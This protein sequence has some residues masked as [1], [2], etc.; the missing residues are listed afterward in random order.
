MAHLDDA[1]LQSLGRSTAA[2]GL[3]TERVY[4]PTLPDWTPK[5]VDN[6]AARQQ[7]ARERLAETLTR[8]LSPPAE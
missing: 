4:L 3:V 5:I 2:N 1:Q 7:V 8:W 6:A